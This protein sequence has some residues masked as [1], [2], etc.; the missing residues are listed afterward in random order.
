MKKLLEYILIT[1]VLIAILVGS[2]FTYLSVLLV[3]LPTPLSRYSPGAVYDPQLEKSLIFGGGIEDSSGY[4]LYD[5][6]WKYDS[7]R[8]IWY[9]IVPTTK[10]SARAGHKM[11]YDTY[12]QKTILFGGWDE[13]FGLRNDIWIYDSQ[14]IQWTEV[15]P[16]ASPDI[17][18]S[19]AMCYDPVYHKVIMFGGYSGSTYHFGDTWVYDYSINLWTELYPTN[20]PSARYGANMAYDHINQRII[21]FGGRNT[22]IMGDTWAYY[23]G[24]NT[25]VELSTSGNPDTRYWHGMAYDSDTNKVVVFGGRHL[26]APGEAL[27]DTWVFNPSSNEWTERHPT[28][29]PTNR[30]EPL[31]VYDP[32]SHRMVLFGGYRFQDITLGDTW[33]YIYSSNSW[34][35]MKSQFP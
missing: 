25:W 3:D 1:V 32:Y 29:H 7:A 21:L 6:M 17:R 14:S 5:D 12:N 18:Q 26:G 24:N 27:D 2:V 35:K 10:P 11:V 22:T 34:S 8:N 28:T 13:I 31:M 4:E 15:F 20:S 30:M 9:E 19:H 23:Y 33:T 16:L